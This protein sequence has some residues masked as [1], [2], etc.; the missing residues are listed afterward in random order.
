MN[1]FMWGSE[2]FAECERLGDATEPLDLA[3]VYSSV[4]VEAS[5]RLKRHRKISAR[6]S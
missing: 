1:P 6:L 3:L 5:D 2:A 4:P